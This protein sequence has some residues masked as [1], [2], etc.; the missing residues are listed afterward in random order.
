MKYLKTKCVL[1]NFYFDEIMSNEFMSNEFLSNEIMSKEIMS[2][3]IMSN[4]NM[5]MKWCQMKI[6]PWKTSQMTVCA[7]GNSDRERNADPAKH[8][9]PGQAGGIFQEEETRWEAGHR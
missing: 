3:E 2:N 1:T 4:E 5:S 8:S 6:C 9:A 7:L